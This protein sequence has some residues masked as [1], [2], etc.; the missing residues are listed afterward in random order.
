M[1]NI[2]NIYI[3]FNN[4]IILCQNKDNLSFSIIDYSMLSSDL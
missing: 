1:V 3:F 4:Y 2:G